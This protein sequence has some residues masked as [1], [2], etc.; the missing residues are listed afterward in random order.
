MRTPKA[1]DTT[2]GKSLPTSGKHPAAAD[3]KEKADLDQSVTT[4]DEQGSVVTAVQAADKTQ[5]GSQQTKPHVEPIS[6]AAAANGTIKPQDVSLSVT[7]LS[8]EA[9]IDC[10]SLLR[11][12]YFRETQV[13]V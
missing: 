3:V 2:P 11:D 9:T 13:K 12:L 7:G 6:I 4:I 8:R 1:E 10:L 5:D